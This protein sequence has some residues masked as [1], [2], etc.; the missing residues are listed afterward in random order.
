MFDLAGNIKLFA[1]LGK[2]CGESEQLSVRLLAVR[3]R[4]V[5]EFKRRQ[6]VIVVI[7]ATA[8][9]E[10][11]LAGRG[12]LSFD[13][14][15]RSAF[16]HLF[17]VFFIIIHADVERASCRATC[18][19][20]NGYA[21]TRARTR[22]NRSTRLRFGNSTSSLT[23]NHCR[24]FSDRRDRFL[25]EVS[26]ALRRRQIQRLLQRTSSRLAL[27]FDR[28]L[29]FL[30][31][32]GVLGSHLSPCLESFRQLADEREARADRIDDDFVESNK[33]EV[34]RE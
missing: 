2:T 25:H 32:F 14:Q 16:D 22:R 12:R 20:R 34:R 6:S 3:W 1:L 9:I 29:R 5:Q 8:R 15:D 30:L 24:L 26:D 7:D 17:R 18:R 27:S 10:W 28:C 23:P 21:N 13:S 33:R 19:R 11:Q 31:Q 4:F